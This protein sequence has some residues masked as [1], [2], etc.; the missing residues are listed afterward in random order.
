MRV[1]F[2]VDSFLIPLLEANL[3]RGARAADV[4]DCVSEADFLSKN[5]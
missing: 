1:L 4:F 2:F 3:S 5:L